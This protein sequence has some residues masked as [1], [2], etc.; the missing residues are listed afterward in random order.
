MRRLL[1][2]MAGILTEVDDP[3]WRRHCNFTGKPLARPAR[4]VGGERA[5][6]IVINVVLP[7]LLAHARLG[8]DKDLELRLHALYAAA[9]PLSAN[10][11]TRRMSAM[12][13][14]S[15]TA[16]RKV[17]DS[18]R[19]QQGLHQIYVDY[20]GTDAGGCERCLVRLNEIRRKRG[21]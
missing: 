13:F 19:M 6:A 21:A 10:T 16:A 17:V 15:D 3:F 2:D 1:S 11:V 20:C 5:S 8:G 18:A 12:L 7:L 14:A 4:L 9:P